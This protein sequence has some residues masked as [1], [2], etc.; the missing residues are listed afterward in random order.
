MRYFDSNA[1]MPL[2]AAAK[3]AWEEAL[4]NLWLNPSSPYRAA[5]RVKTRLEDAR[6]RVASLLGVSSTRVV[7]NSGATEGNNS[8]FAYWSTA[9][10]ESARIGISPTEHPSVIESAKYYFGERVEWL[11]L[12]PSGAV[13]IEAIN[14]KQMDGISVMAAN[15]ETGILNPWQEIA[16]AAKNAGV[17][18]HCDASQWVGKGQLNKIG[19]CG[20][21]TA[22]GHKFGGPQ[23]VGF[24]V[25]PEVESNFIALHGGAQ[26]TGRRAGTE[27]VASILAMVA[28]LQAAKIGN[29]NGRD[30]L[31]AALPEFECVGLDAPRLWNTA[32][33][34]APKFASSRWI[35]ALEVRGF[36][37]G[38]GA[39]CATGKAGPSSVLEAMGYL[40][41][42]MSR[43]LRLSANAETTAKDWS[44]LAEAVRVVYQ[45]L[46]SEEAKQS[47]TTVIDL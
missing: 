41:S 14:F 13:A 12:D 39:A 17:L 37:V 28:A 33:L 11:A 15:H 21:V 42:A 44:D 1:T 4:E 23:G 35:R 36:L 24:W 46:E 38:S 6:S 32:L 27:N 8:I 26:E 19:D 30:D 43:T 2:C 45:E 10:P 40:P 34:I 47:L 31:I 9:L 20:Y 29:V 16:N 22:C 3:V 7:F 25:L 5:A 18:Y